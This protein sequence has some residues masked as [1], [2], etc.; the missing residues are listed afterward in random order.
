M[1][2]I[3]R[4]NINP[5]LVR[6]IKLPALPESVENLQN[7]LKVKL[8]IE[9]EF[10]IQYEDPDFDNRPCNLIEINELPTER[11]VLHLV[12]NHTS[13]PEPQTSSD[14]TSISSLDTASLTSSASYSP[15]SVIQNYRRNT[16][17][18][19]HPFPIPSFSYDIE[20]K[21]RKGN[22]VY[23]KT[24][25]SL[26]VTR[27][28]KIGILDKLAEEIFSIK[29]YPDKN[30]VTSVAAELVAKHPCLK[31]PGSGSGYDGWGDSI[32]YKLGN[33]RSK[34]RDAGCTEVV[35]N[36][37]RREG[38]DGESSRFTL[39]K[40]RR[41]EVNFMPQNPEKYDDHALEEERCIM[42]DEM[43]KRGKDMPL[44]KQKMDLTF[45]LR[46]KEIV[47]V[48]PLV[49]EVQLRWP[50]LFLEEQICAEFR[51]ITTKDL[52]ETFMTALD[53]Y[54]IRLIRL[55]RARKAAFNK[56]MD[57]LLQ[58]FDEQ[59]SNLVQHRRMISLEGLPMFVRDTEGKLFVTCMDTDPVE[60]FVKG[61]KVGILTVL[62]DDVGP[63]SAPT[64]VNIAIVLE[65]DIVLADLSD[66]PS[67]FA[68]LFGLL[69]GL[70]ME[71]PK[72]LRYTF[73]VV[74]HIFMELTP[75]CS[76]RVRSLKTKLLV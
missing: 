18:W 2:L 23:E 6:K 24:G 33:Y 42:V 51:R 56:E 54:S 72:E 29:A 41:G 45:S 55:F 14:T 66:L 37:K 48:Q 68:Y 64:V 53:T 3:L 36:R 49:M 21:L 22:E 11:A 74:Q 69:Y 60:R 52:M 65:E 4:V 32:K 27:D 63:A 13:A 76:R 31:D 75:N 46:R 43:K 50:A 12:W 35:V 44:I 26:E 70:N 9:E 10:T 1:A 8:G 19:P 15:S 58:R 16:S 39:K 17:Q 61:V 7:E 47:E 25:A 67:A 73:E 40:P 34:L 62:E 57:H 28:M 5:K 71:F 20:L 38:D 30:E 59:V